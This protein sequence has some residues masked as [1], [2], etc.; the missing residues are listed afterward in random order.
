MRRLAV[1]ALFAL[2]AACWPSRQW[3]PV[4]VDWTF[5]GQSCIDAGVDSVQI[6]VDGEILTPNKFTCADAS[7]GAD[8]GD[9]ITGP[10]VMTVTGFDS[11]GNVLYQTTQNVQVRPSGKNI[12]T[13]DAA[14]TTGDA[15]VRWGFDGKTCD[16]AGVTAVRV[17]VDGQVIT[18]AKNN[19]DL[20]CKGL[21][22]EGTTI[23]PLSPGAHSF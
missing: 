20:P 6:D 8:L 2:S 7:Q 13:I 17:S 22:F 21:S 18:D 9:F 23:G 12:I 14:P 19:P 11:A 5:G 3:V 15:E 10:Y 1:I 16:A 4:E